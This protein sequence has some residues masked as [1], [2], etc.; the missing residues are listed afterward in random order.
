MYRDYSNPLYK[1]WRKDIYKRD[2]FQCQMPGCGSKKRIEAHHIRTW[3]SFPQLRLDR[4]NGVTLCSRCHKKVTKNEQQWES[5]FI[6][7]V[8]RNNAKK[9]K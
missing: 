2:S 5:I 7:I 6:K 9:K 4:N 3:A 1:E 8:A